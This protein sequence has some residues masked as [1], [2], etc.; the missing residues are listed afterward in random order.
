MQGCFRRTHRGSVLSLLSLRLSAHSG[1]LES[2][3]ISLCYPSCQNLSR[4]Q[5]CVFEYPS[6]QRCERDI[7]QFICSEESDCRQVVGGLWLTSD[8]FGPAVDHDPVLARWIHD[9]INPKLRTHL[10]CEP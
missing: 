10:Y 1:T 2:L 4:K 3:C 8:H 9:F 7:A 5:S 6:N